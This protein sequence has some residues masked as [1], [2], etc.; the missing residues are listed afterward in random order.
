MKPFKPYL[1][2]L[3]GLFPLLTLLLF[4]FSPS[5]AATTPAYEIHG[6][7]LDPSGAV[8][9]GAQVTAYRQ[10]QTPAGTAVTS[11]GGEFLLSEL[12]AGSYEVVVHAP[13]MAAI[14]AAVSVPRAEAKPL[15]FIL[16]I[17]PLATLVTVTP[18]RGEVENAFNLP[19]QVN[20]VGGEKL[21]SR[22]GVILPQALREEVGVMVQQTNAPQGEVVIRGLT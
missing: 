14:S 18:G 3:R 10:G 21:L 9:A 1:R 16:Q 19:G 12:A 15:R 11:E 8:I 6:Q 13:G 4:V 22:P 20:V 7:V 2:S 17:A 5:A